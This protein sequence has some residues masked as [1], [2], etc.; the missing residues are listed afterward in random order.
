MSDKKNLGFGCVSL[1]QQTFLKDAHKLLSIAYDNGITHFDT[2]PVYSNGYSEKIVGTFIKKKRSEVTVTTK[3]GLGNIH[4]PSLNISLALAVNAVKRT[5][6]KSNQVNNITQPTK[7]SHRKIEVDYVRKSLKNSLKN[8]QT[9]YIDYYLLHEAL[10]SFLTND[11]IEFLKREVEKGVIK[12]L[13]IAAAYVNITDLS[14]RNLDGFDVLQYENGLHYKTDE[15]VNQF[16]NKT[17][18]YHSSLKSLPVIKSNHTRN[19]IVGLLLN[20]AA[21]QNPSGKVLF[22]TTSSK[23]LKENI[24]SFNEYNDFSLQELN[25]IVDAF[26]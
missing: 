15:L 21:K 22:S 26:H 14:T 25:G 13:G 17:H 9:D 12:K 5:L 1:T 3:C 2:A 19:Q 24:K 10:P 7:L 18:F 16:P 23:R 20:R 8:L 4:Q 11:A 6:K